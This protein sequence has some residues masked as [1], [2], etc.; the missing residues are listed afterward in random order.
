MNEQKFV[1]GNMKV[2]K[3]GGASLQDADS[4]KQLTEIIVAHQSQNLVIVVSAMGKTTQALE[5]IFQQKLSNQPYEKSIEAI[6]VFHQTIVETLLGNACQQAQQALMDW[7]L[8][9]TLCLQM[10]CATHNLDKL[11]SSLV[12]W[13][14]LLASKIVYDYLQLQAVPCKWLDARN[15]IKTYLGFKDA[16]IDWH[17]T[18]TLV[19]Q[20]L[21]PVFE[22]H[23]IILT[24]GFIGSNQAGD[25]T[26]L[27]K[28]GSDFTGAILANTL[29]AQSLT[30]WKDVPGIM[31]ADP[32]QFQETTKFDQLSYKDMAKMAFYGAQVLHPQT[33]QPLAIK[34]IPLYVKPFY[35]WQA[36]GTIIINEPLKITKPIYM[37]KTNQC[38]VSLHVKDFTFLDEQ[39]LSMIF[40]HLT[41]LAVKV[42]MLERSAY[43]L[44]LC[45]N[46]DWLKLKRLSKI[47]QPQFVV[48][49]NSPV[50]LL[51]IMHQADGLSEKYLLHKTVL[52]EQQC[53]QLYQVVFKETYP[54]AHPAN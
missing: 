13:G 6:Y 7:K 33:I 8:Q 16:Q 53:Q 49:H 41:K 29:H 14:E 45:L 5:T 52:L 12:A 36:T 22:Q 51:T 11:Y 3:F 37:L 18:Q 9:L 30:I 21:L 40:Q 54:Y 26:T 23:P 4:I 43:S 46:N 32:K 17:S 44:C 39:K 2:F 42:N 34:N 47:W 48:A 35:D 1:V 20:K 15:Y 27:G 50:S 24:Q 28:E 25:T 38:L 10:P 19:N 31:S